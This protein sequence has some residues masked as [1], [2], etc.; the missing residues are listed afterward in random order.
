MENLYREAR[1]KLP[2]GWNSRRAFDRVLLLLDKQS[3]PGWPIC[4]SASSIGQWLFGESLTPNPARA[5]ELW[6]Q[7]QDVFQGRYDHHFKV[8]VKA[9]V[10]TLAKA[11]ENRWRL[12]MASSLPVQVAWHMTVG[13]LER[14]LLASH[15][16]HPSA[17]GQVYTAGGW[18]Q[19]LHRVRATNLHWCLDKSGWDWNSPGWVY[20]VCKELRKRLT[21]H[22]DPE[23]ES[24]L[25]LL[26]ADAYKHS[27]VVLSSGE[28]FQQTDEGLMKSGLVVT[29]SD[30]SFAQIAEHVAAEYQLGLEP[31]PILAT[32][33]DTIQRRP[34]N[35]HEYTAC[36]Q[37]CGSVVKEAV[38]G[39]QFM[40]FSLSD[41][42]MV[43][44]YVGKH[45]ASV[46][47]QK[48]EFLPDTLEQYAGMYV[49]DLEMHHFWRDVATELGISL[50][51]YQYYRYVCDNPDAHET[52][53]T[54]RTQFSDRAVGG[55]KAAEIV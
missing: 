15:G 44:M 55:D 1:A 26:Y 10:H 42:G 29:I 3:S 50:P 16:R 2:V 41:G 52:F 17:Y 19:F 8:F 30:N 53:S 34:L 38:D 37:G 47:Y 54:S 25:D 32:G 21:I 27:K 45:V 46:K 40:G 20:Q 14:S 4:R 28:V 11:K 18:K 39:I 31:T 51:S 9:E 5:N 33:D 23:W 13:H 48:R 22:S 7:V 36:L 43:P 24:A 12:I 6:A 49:H 35:I